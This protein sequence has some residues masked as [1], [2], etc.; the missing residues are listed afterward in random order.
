MILKTA[1]ESGRLAEHGTSSAL[2][3]FVR[4]TEGCAFTKAQE[5]KTHLTQHLL[6]ILPL[7]LPF[8]GER[9]EELCLSASV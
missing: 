2:S 7:Q 6:A 9:N 3:A 1:V 5:R 4:R 8:L